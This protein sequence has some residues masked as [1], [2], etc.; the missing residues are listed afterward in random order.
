[1]R[2][3]RHK[4]ELSMLVL[5]ETH[6]FTWD[7]GTLDFSAVCLHRLKVCVLVLED[8]LAQFDSLALNTTDSLVLK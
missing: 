3:L 7:L 8:G 2:V 5:I 4:R 6:K 1:M